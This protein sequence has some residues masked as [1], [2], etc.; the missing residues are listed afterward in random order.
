MNTEILKKT[1]I[2]LLLAAVALFSITVITPAAVNV[3][4][5]RNTF[6]QLDKEIGNTLKLTAGATAVS[7]VITLLPDDT[8]TPIAE[9]FAE[10]G[11][12]FVIVLS[13]LY[14]EKY[15]ITILMRAHFRRPLPLHPRLRLRRKMRERLRS[16]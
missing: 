5:H 4:H 6:E 1:A 10:L 15:L 12:Y 9:Q 8:C 3:D 13:A 16:F 11:T 2:A 14:L 7:A